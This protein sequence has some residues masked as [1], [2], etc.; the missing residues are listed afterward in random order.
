MQKKLDLEAVFHK[1]SVKIPPADA[2]LAGFQ[3]REGAHNG[4][5]GGGG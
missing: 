4:V 1:N 2:N 5:L 3:F